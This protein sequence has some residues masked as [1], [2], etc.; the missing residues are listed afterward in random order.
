MLLH[1]HPTNPNAREVAQVACTLQQDG[2]IICPTDTVYAFMCALNSKKAY[3]TLLRIKGVKSKDANFSFVF[4]NLSYLA[5]YA[6][7]DNPTFKVLKQNLPGAFTFILK[8]SGK[9][10]DKLQNRRKSIGVRI[11][12]SRIVVALLEQLGCPLLTTSTKSPDEV[13]EY[14]TD[15][16]ELDERY[17]KLV[18]IVIDGGAGGNVPSTIIDCTVQPYELVREGAGVLI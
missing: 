1:I 8:A 10:P 14:I 2:V 12:N 16:A 17:G 11:P 15:P 13:L 4:P 9:V 3:E 18:D 6:K 7:V 5:D